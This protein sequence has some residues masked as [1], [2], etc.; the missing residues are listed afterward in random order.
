MKI[1]RKTTWRDK[2]EEIAG[3]ERATLL[4]R[5]QE[6]LCN[7]PE[8]LS[9]QYLYG[10]DFLLFVIK[11]FSLWGEYWSSVLGFRTL[12]YVTD[13]KEWNHGWMLAS[14]HN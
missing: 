13:G 1:I 7:N 9:C 4:A 2:R 10:G 5:L 11:I 12:V 14:L 6:I 8:W 3:E